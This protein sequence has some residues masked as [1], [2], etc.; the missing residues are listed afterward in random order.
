MPL[1]FYPTK[2]KLTIICPLAFT[3]SGSNLPCMLLSFYPTRFE[4]TASGKPTT[5]LPRHCKSMTTLYCQAL[6]VWYPLKLELFL[7]LHVFSDSFST[8]GNYYDTLITRLRIVSCRVKHHA[9]MT[10][11]LQP[12]HNHS[13]TALLKT[14]QKGST[15]ILAIEWLLRTKIKIANLT[16]PNW[17]HYE[18][19]RKKIHYK[20]RE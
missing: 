3:L 2:F 14:T 19:C 1:S 10:T 9:V 11:V 12:D 6:L 4:A 20:F 17:N 5:A 15:K 8:C 7:H 13:L 18:R 16:V